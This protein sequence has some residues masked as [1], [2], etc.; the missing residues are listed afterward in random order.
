MVLLGQAAVVAATPST[1]PTRYPS[2]PPEF[3]RRPSRL[4]TYD[5]TIM[6]APDT[7]PPTIT[8]TRNP[9]LRPQSTIPTQHPIISRSPDHTKPPIGVPTRTPL[10]PSRYPWSHME[11]YNES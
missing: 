5:A 10:S 6:K 8:P 4:P 11:T 9:S 1:S 7:K 3:T 2:L